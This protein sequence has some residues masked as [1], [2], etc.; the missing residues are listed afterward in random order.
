MTMIATHDSNLN[1]NPQIVSADFGTGTE[2]MRF[3]IGWNNVTDEVNDVRLL[4]VDDNGIM[5]TPSQSPC[6]N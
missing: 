1:Q 6:P 3:V 5:S 4:A 2:I